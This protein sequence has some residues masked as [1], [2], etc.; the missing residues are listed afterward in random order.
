METS[1]LQQYLFE[2][3]KKKLAPHLSLVDEVA[4]I[5]SIS[6]DSAYRRIRG[7]KP[8][9][10]E[11]LKNLALH[12][13]LSLDAIL[14]LQ[15]DSTVFHGN[16]V[17]NQNFDFA[18]YLKDMLRQLQHVQS[19]EKKDFYYE[20]KDIPPFHYFQFPDLAA[21]K[22]F[23]W[24]KTILQY[25]EYSKSVYEPDKLSGEILDT[26]KKI[27]ES[28]CA[29]PSVE[30]WSV[31]VVNITIRQI[32]FYKES[33]VFKK[34]EQI[35]VLY[36]QFLALIE[37]IEKQAEAGMKF[38]VDKTSESS[39]APFKLCYNEVMLGHNTIL[40]IT[41]DTKIVFLNHGILNYLI[42]TDERFCNYTHE[43]LQNLMRKSILISAAGEKER[44]KFFNIL[45][46]KIT[47]KRE[48]ISFS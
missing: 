10:F 24:M 1:N 39:I 44:N 47:E 13:R 37:H 9:A 28:Y 20:A 35:V 3:I 29:I 30:L 48:M 42:T 27:I 15:S 17:T 23:F 31:E 6:N 22:Y 33:G 2:Q 26:G 36:D 7:E 34:P 21:F 38:L 11:E 19:F 41:G 12:Y 46:N 4:E 40:A 32:E 16:Y 8:L 45:K 18:T 25:P 5:L 43:S 14:N